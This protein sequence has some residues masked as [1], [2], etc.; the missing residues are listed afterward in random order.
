MHFV[1]WNPDASAHILV[2]VDGSSLGNSGCAG[3]GVVI[4]NNSGSW[5]EGATG[6]IGVS[7]NLAAELHG[8]LQGLLRVRAL[9]IASA[10]LLSDSQEALRLNTDGSNKNHRYACLLVKI[11]VIWTV[12]VSASAIY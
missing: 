2:H 11:N 4:R 6:F 8:I 12:L 7:N 10:L 9:D 5:I 3:F 1:G